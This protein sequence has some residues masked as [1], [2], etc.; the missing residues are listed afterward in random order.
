MER[1]QP[2]SNKHSTDDIVHNKTHNGRAQPAQVGGRYLSLGVPGALTSPAA[3]NV[4]V[5]GLLANWIE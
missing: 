1:K 4:R 2:R 3:L 5:S